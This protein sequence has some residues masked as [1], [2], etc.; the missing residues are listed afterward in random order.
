MRVGQS[1]ASLI[2][3]SGLVACV[4]SRNSPTLCQHMYFVVISQLYSCVGNISYNAGS[5]FLITPENIPIGV[6][7]PIPFICF[8][9]PDI[10]SPF[11]ICTFTF[12]PLSLP[13]FL[14]FRS[15]F[16]GHSPWSHS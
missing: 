3:N 15:G 10:L 16:L 4:P 13:R 1:M 7:Q 11:L 6:E 5:V 9:L 2:L 14:N 12:L 8:C